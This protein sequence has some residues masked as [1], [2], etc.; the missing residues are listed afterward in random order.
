[1]A[2]YR[3]SLITI[4]LLLSAGTSAPAKAPQEKPAGA[5]QRVELGPN[6]VWR[7]DKVCGVNCLYIL[8]RMKGH[9]ANYTSLLD[10][11]IVAP[12]KSVASLA[13]LKEVAG[14]HG[15]QCAIGKTTPAG[16]KGL[17]PPVIAHLEDVTQNGDN[18]GHFVLVLKS[19]DDG[20]TYLD[21]STAETF[22]KPWQVFERRWSGFVLYPR[23]PTSRP[24]LWC[25]CFA[26]GLSLIALVRLLHGRRS[27]KST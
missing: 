12:G 13:D 25:S 1:V 11:L 7:H 8:L 5:S 21:G 6:A 9:V 4:A 19:N 14:R 24:F 17:A 16:L 22:T 20:V 26:L 23:S 3:G 27:P 15:V 10:E 18:F 2:T